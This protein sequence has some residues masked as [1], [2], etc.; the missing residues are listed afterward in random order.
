MWFPRRDA[1]R[2]LGDRVV[3]EVQRAEWIGIRAAGRARFTRR[4]RVLPHGLP[5]ALAL[6]CINAIVRRS[7]GDC[8]LVTLVA[9]G[10]TPSAAFSPSP[11]R[12]PASSGTTGSGCTMRV[13]AAPG[14]ELTP[15][16]PGS[17]RRRPRVVSGRSGL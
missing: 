13:R 10:A 14:R 5:V 8:A 2:A 15:R 3:A 4:D 6:V 17:P 7:Y 12:A 16:R 9:E 1:F 11:T